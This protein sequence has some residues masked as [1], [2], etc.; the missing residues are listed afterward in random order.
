[1]GEELQAS[2]LLGVSSTLLGVGRSITMYGRIAHCPNM[3][4]Y[5]SVPSQ[6]RYTYNT[7][8]LL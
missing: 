3:Q 8:L 4:L 1:M 2:T 5:N 6:D 7:F